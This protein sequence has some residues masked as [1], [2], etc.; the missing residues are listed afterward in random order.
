M[1]PIITSNKHF[2]QQLS[3][4]I[5]SGSIL[6][7]VLVNAVAKGAARP[8]TFDVEE[9]ATIKAVYLEYWADANTISK[10]AVWCVVKRP[11]SVAGPTFANMNLLIGYPNKK[12][13]FHSGQGL[14]PSNGNQM[15]LFKGWVKIPKG[16]Q[17][18][19]LADSLV[20]VVAPTG[21]TINVCGLSI[22]KEYD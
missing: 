12:N 18:F 8:N 4:P 11:A 5:A 3:V 13:I 14:I 16:K 20:M 1:R 10:S 7:I 21:S 2:V 9:G 22:Y 6:S 15:V 19:G 17:R